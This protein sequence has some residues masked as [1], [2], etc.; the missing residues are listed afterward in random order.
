M[1]IEDLVL[2]FVGVPA[3]FGIVSAI[4]CAKLVSK[5]PYVIILFA[6]LGILIGLGIGSI[7]N[8]IKSLF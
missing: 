5:K 1:A 3:L 4:I 7:I 8:S 2:K 6:A